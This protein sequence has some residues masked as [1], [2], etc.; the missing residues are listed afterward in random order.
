VV[1]NRRNRNE[2]GR[3]TEKHK[4]I[5]GGEKT[6]RRTGTSNKKHKTELKKK[7]K[8]KNGFVQ[9]A[10]LKDLTGGSPF[11]KKKTSWH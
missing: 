1:K 7:K 10:S 4:N 2:G 8:K 5:T 3:R 9:K 11:F 6:F